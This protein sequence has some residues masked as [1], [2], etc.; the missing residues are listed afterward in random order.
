MPNVDITG[1]SR[2][3]AWGLSARAAL[4]CT[5]FSVL[6]PTFALAGQSTVETGSTEDPAEILVSARAFRDKSS[7]SSAKLDLPL[8]DTPQSISVISR[9]ALQAVGA[10]QVLDAVQYVPGVNFGGS[11]GLQPTVRSRGFF[12]SELFG[13][14]L[15]G[16]NLGDDITIDPVVVERVEFVKG[17]NSISYGQNSPGGF[18]NVV[19]RAPGSELAG[20]FA[21][22][23]GSFRNI[24]FEGDV[25]GPLNESGTIKGLVAAAYETSDSF[26]DFGDEESR[27]VYGTLVTELTPRLTFTVRALYQDAA[28][29]VNSGIGGVV[30]PEV[31]DQPFLPKLPFDFFGG[32]PWANTSIETTYLQGSIAYQLSESWTVSA[33]AAYSNNDIRYQTAEPYGGNGVDGFIGPDGDTILYPYF[34]RDRSGG[35]LG[36]IRV[37]GTFQLFGR[38]Q[39]VLMFADYK[40]RTF[41]NAGVYTDETTILN[42]FEP[43]YFAYPN[44]FGPGFVGPEVGNRTKLSAY[45]A[46]ANVNLEVTDK[47]SFL[48]G[49]RYDD[50]TSEVR[51]GA[52]DE[53][54]IFKASRFT[55][56]AAAVYSFAPTSNIYYSYSESFEPSNGFTCDGSTVAP[57]IARQ[58]EAGVKSEFNNGALLLSAAVFDIRQRNSV[59]SDP[60]PFCDGAVIPAGVYGSQGLEIELLGNITP[61]WNVIG[62]YS[63]TDANY[64][65]AGDLEEDPDII[66]QGSPNTPRHKFTLF[67]A[68]DIASGPLQ[69]LGFGAGYTYLGAR[70]ADAANT[71]TLPAANNF[72]AA[73]YFKGIPGIELSLNVRNITNERIYGSRFE[74]PY[75]YITLDPPR[76][77]LASM[78]MRY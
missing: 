36:E 26:V 65:G 24:R 53:A 51:R 31:S 3:G 77:V 70:P 32:L 1:A 63:Y 56:R 8:V 46:A 15:D 13:Y 62:G 10:V 23:G 45:G 38:D 7:A 2:T 72:D 21:L 55:P 5:L 58:H 74:D 28:Q 33:F 11:F 47:L 75:G 29:V 39:Q 61:E 76:T 35:R 68:Y 19:S 43:D 69:G 34:A 54:S 78:R 41:Q 27:A 48:L 67:T 40:Q 30:D 20:G 60:N 66:G 16:L 25:G 37:G 17:A 42:I 18:I 71:L 49:L 12:V 50:A 6:P 14:M 9:E 59:I 64:L 22:R 44:P 52:G 73:V 4:L 57:Q